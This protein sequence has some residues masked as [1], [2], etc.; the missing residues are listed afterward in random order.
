M[1]LENRN[2]INSNLCTRCGA[3]FA[4]DNTG[5][6]TKNIDGYPV[7]KGD[8]G[9]ERERLINLCS[10]WRW[11]YR[12][13]MDQVHGSHVSYDPSTPDIG[14]HLG[15]GIAYSTSRDAVEKGQSGGV[16]TTLLRM[17]LELR[18]FD[19]CLG[20][21][22]PSADE[23]NPFLSVPKVIE[24]PEDVA[25]FAGSK[26]AICPSLELLPE[27][28]VNGRS[29]CMTLLPCQ[30]AGFYQL[31]R[32][33]QNEYLEQCKLIIGP[34]CGLNMNW[35][36]GKELVETM[37]LD[38]AR[39]KR[40]AN[41]GGQFPGVTTVEMIDGTVNYLDRTA[42][43]ALYRMFSPDRC[44][45]CTDYG[46]ELAD[47]SV[48][49]VWMKNQEGYVY[50]NGAAWLIARTP[51]G[52]QFIDL[53]VEKNYLEYKRV[54]G[55]TCGENWRGAFEYRK[56]RAFNRIHQYA[57][58]GIAVPEHD[59]P[60]PSYNEQYREADDVEMA[61]RRI[62][63]NRLVR[64]LFLRWWVRAARAVRADGRCFRFE[65]RMFE[66]LRTKVFTHQAN[67]VRL[68]HLPWL[69]AKYV[70]ADI[71]TK[72]KKITPKP[73]RFVAKGLFYCVRHPIRALKKCIRL[74]G[75]RR[76]VFVKRLDVGRKRI[77]IA[78]GY[79]YGNTGDEAQLGANLQRWA[80]AAPDAEVIVLSPNPEYTGKHH[81]VQAVAASRVV[82]F[83]SSQNPDYGASNKNFE[84][85]FWRTKRRL[86]PAAWC[87]KH[88]LPLFTVSQREA[89]FLQLLSSAS[90]LHLSGGGYLT[91]MTRSRLWDHMLLLRL[92]KIFGVQTI[93]TGHT[94][95]V[96]KSRDDRKLAKWGLSCA[97]SIT[98][99]DR[100]ESIRALAAIGVTGDHIQ[101]RFDDALF[102]DQIDGKQVAEYV[103]ATGI[104]ASKPYVAASFHYWGQDKE[105][106]ERLVSRFAELCD[107]L[108]HEYDLQ[109]IFVPMIKKD[110]HAIR[111]CIYA[112]KE[113]GAMLQYSYDYK[114]V[115][116]IIGEAKMC[117]AMK[118]HPIVF[119]MANAVP[120]IGV[121]VDDYYLHKNRGAL[122]LFGMEDWMLDKS[123]IFLP[124]AEQMLKDIISI[125][126]EMCAA[127]EERD[128]HYYSLFGDDEVL[129]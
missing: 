51:R 9:V 85:T 45:T 117:L 47:I 42:H 25:L 11:S 17:G 43:R 84:K 102:C 78:G 74:A 23:G 123:S 116:G 72:F 39:V 96:F 10:G 40:F 91:G 48:A 120:T 106:S 18:C 53:A 82:F 76:P 71:V 30:T 64:K 35:E 125:H 99:R 6:L 28:A 16:T 122:A 44:F 87:M 101:E 107:Y 67:V 46:N 100:N 55:I 111:D 41:R 21:T 20:V 61:C 118:H 15:I 5:A 115:K 105:L 2:L 80:E 65:R 37:G 88:G 3:C 113:P 8:D 50:P 1:H 62:F 33:V 124:L 22:R 108:V 38:P 92:C 19:A 121:A 89:E 36:V 112:M 56:L 34:F 103:A 129:L 52:Q 31:A 27:L 69:L 77:L 54:D 7:F 79:G 98:V 24:R 4:A 83:D 68:R 95:G 29:F 86:M 49:D 94:I 75:L 70:C 97:E 13:L 110:E 126:R 32:T 90:V 63:K 57:K 104:D 81:G 109:V 128:N 12:A 59:F 114:V 26:Y 66:V 73:L 119:A 58:A 60:V 93:L 127:I 14:C